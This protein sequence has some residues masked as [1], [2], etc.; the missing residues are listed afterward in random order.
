[1]IRQSQTRPANQAAGGDRLP[2][3]A[4]TYRRVQD[5]LERLRRQRLEHEEEDEAII[6][7]RLS[8]VETILARAEIVEHESDGQTVAIGSAVTLLDQE[9]GRTERY[10]IDGAHGS[11][12]ADVISALSPMGTGL[13]GSERGDVVRVELPSGRVRMFTV[14]DVA[15]QQAVA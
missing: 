11:M 15:Q 14:L 7:A 12:D 13:I 10:V 3:T 2:L 1:M 9:S 6:N 5:E 4:E 8:R